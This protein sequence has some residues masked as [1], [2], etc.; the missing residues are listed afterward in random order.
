MGEMV[1]RVIMYAHAQEDK[2]KTGTKIIDI[3]AKMTLL[4]SAMK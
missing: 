4:F 2:E 1:V 3:R